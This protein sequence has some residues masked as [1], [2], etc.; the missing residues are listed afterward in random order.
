MSNILAR[1]CYSLGAQIDPHPLDGK[2][3]RKYLADAT[4]Y[5]LRL[6][7]NKLGTKWGEYRGSC[8]LL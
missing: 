1:P 3:G 6:S 4:G 5:G 7:V 8:P 2:D